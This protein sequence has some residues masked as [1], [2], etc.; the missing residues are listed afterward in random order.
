MTMKDQSP[1]IISEL[2][3]RTG[4]NNHQGVEKKRPLLFMRMFYAE[5]FSLGNLTIN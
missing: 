3:I 1:R 2:P 4:M 5:L